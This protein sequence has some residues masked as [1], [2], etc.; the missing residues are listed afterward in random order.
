MGLYRGLKAN[1]V[2]IFSQT[3]G[4]EGMARASGRCWRLLL[5]YRSDF[6]VISIRAG[7]LV[8][9]LEDEIVEY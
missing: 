2:L 5:E 1:S 3:L 9:N 8:S 6:S 7:R 4:T